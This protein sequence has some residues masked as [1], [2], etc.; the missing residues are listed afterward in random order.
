M[1]KGIENAFFWV[2]NVGVNSSFAHKGE[3][4]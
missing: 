1:E 4:Q 3:M 2:Y